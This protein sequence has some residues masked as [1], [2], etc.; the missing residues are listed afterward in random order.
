M[1]GRFCCKKIRCGFSL[2]E[3]MVVIA[4]VSGV[5]FFVFDRVFIYQELAEKTAVEITV[6]HIRNSLR[7]RTAE[8]LLRG[9]DKEIVSLVGGNAIRWLEAPPPGYLGELKMVRWNEVPRGSWYFDLDKGEIVYCVDRGRHFATESNGNKM[10]R[11]R[12]TA[13]FHKPDGDKTAVLAEGIELM[14]LEKY[15]WL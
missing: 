15:H 14:L 7:Y 6:L 3:L 10:L 4:V 13:L 11:F 12:V 1:M 5:I 2:F 9:Q 8:M